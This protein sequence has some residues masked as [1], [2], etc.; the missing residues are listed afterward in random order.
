M[1]SPMS[2]IYQQVI[3]N[4]RLASDP[5]ANVWVNASAGSGKTKVLVDRILRLLLNGTDPKTI[6]CITFT[7]AAAYEMYDR[8]L[9][10][11]ESWSIASDHELKS[12]L[13]QL[14]PEFQL[15]P[16]FLFKARQLFNRV[17]D[18][19]VQIQTI[20]SFAQR[21]LSSC[22]LDSNLPFAA[23]LM[24]EVDE[25]NTRRMIKQALD[26]TLDNEL[27]TGELKRLYTTFSQ[28]KFHSIVHKV[29]DE[30]GFFRLIL[31]EGVDVFRR[32]LQDYLH[33]PRTEQ[34]VLNEIKQ[35]DVTVFAPLSTVNTASDSDL[36]FIRNLLTALS[37]CQLEELADV[38]LTDKGTPRKRL[39]SKKVMDTLPEVSQQLHALADRVYDLDQEL[40]KSRTITATFSVV[41]I[42]EELLS[43]YST[44]KRHHGVMDYDDLIFH[45][46]E[47]LSN[48]ATAQSILYRLDSTINHILIDEAQ[49]TNLYQW[50]LIDYIIDNFFQSDIH[51]TIFVV[52]DHKQSIFGFQG[53]DPDIFHRI[54]TYYANKPSVCAWNDI[55]LDV[56]FRSLQ[57]ILE[58]TD[59][60]FK[61]TSL[62]TPYTPHTS[63]RGNGGRVIVHPLC[64]SD[65][66]TSEDVHEQLANQI[67][68]QVVELCQSRSYE[69]I[70]IL[71]RK[72]G[73]HLDQVQHVFTQRAIPFAAP[74]RNFMHQD[75]LVQLVMQ[76]ITLSNQPYD[77]ATLMQLLLNPLLDLGQTALDMAIDRARSVEAFSSD[78]W[79]A[80]PQ[81]NT[82]QSIIATSPTSEI[83][84]L[85]ICMWAMQYLNVDTHQLAN[86]LT[87]YDFLAHWVWDNDD[88]TLA[89]SEYSHWI[90]SIAIPQGSRVNKGAVR[91][92]TIHG[93]KGLQAS[94]V[95][96]MD[97]TQPPV[98]RNVWGHDDDQNVF[99]CTPQRRD[100]SA[101]YQAL[102][103][104]HKSNEMKEYYRLLY[105]ALTRAADELHIFGATKS[106]LSPE[107]WYALC[108]KTQP[109]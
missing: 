67:A 58:F 36:Q 34:A 40:K 12:K 89:S 7:Q 104:Q 61:E 79:Q 19:P 82:L 59:T 99:L 88:Y 74:N 94:V 87:V 90:Q 70:L 108:S 64:T 46:I 96:L 23:R 57:A 47:L 63:F 45:A 39:L 49:D 48:S 100:E 21:I 3:Q 43:T 1:H 5:S 26:H 29:L 13:D 98:S 73:E 20:H 68:D 80:L 16:S 91:I 42:A 81:I 62:L 53:T 15:T 106:K 86:A 8:L 22:P 107:S 76:V 24:D 66:N 56:S 11:L 4:Q 77:H 27:T 101:E 10:H 109:N 6:V 33:N 54:K 35:M 65:E 50:K 51:K 18:E 44:L 32:K 92:L 37:S 41:R 84:Y 14:D 38:L 69:D 17:L 60:L 78:L 25:V 93:A 85:S 95:I 83:M 52:G 72:R 9:T 30:Q 102:K 75:H 55:S 2:Q 105:V 103:A 97:T 31:L 71:I 28:T